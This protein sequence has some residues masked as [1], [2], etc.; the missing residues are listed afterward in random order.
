MTPFSILLAG[1]AG[2]GQFCEAHRESSIEYLQSISRR[3]GGDAVDRILPYLTHH[4]TKRK[5][6]K[7]KDDKT[8]DSQE[9]DEL[10]FH[11][12]ATYD[13]RT[14]SA[15]VRAFCSLVFKLPGGK[16]E[17]A[18]CVVPSFPVLKRPTPPCRCCLPRPTQIGEGRKVRMLP[19][20]EHTE[21]RYSERNIEGNGRFIPNSVS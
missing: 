2:L 6:K 7:K 14:V 12:V 17:S 1:H 13:S 20:Q 4:N 10:E 11:L 5:E 3:G 18:I 19:G 8:K 15:K 16:G 21:G 9:T